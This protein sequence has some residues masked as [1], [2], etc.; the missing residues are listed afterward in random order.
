MPLT[1]PMTAGPALWTVYGRLV[2]KSTISESGAMSAPYSSGRRFTSYEMPS[3]WS[4]CR[5]ALTCQVDM[6]RTEPSRRCALRNGAVRSIAWGRDPGANLACQ[7]VW[8]HE[9]K[10][11][12]VASQTPASATAGGRRLGVRGAGRLALTRAAYTRYPRLVHRGVLALSA[13]LLVGALASA[14][15]QGRGRQTLPTL[16]WADVRELAGE[17]R[18]PTTREEPVSPE[19]ITRTGRVL[20][21]PLRTPEGAPAS[22]PSLATGLSTWA[23][24][25]A[26]SSAAP[27]A[28][29]CATPD[30]FC[31]TF[32]DAVELFGASALAELVYGSRPDAARERARRERAVDVVLIGTVTTDPA[33]LGI[34]AVVL[35]AASGADVWRGHVAGASWD[36]V[37]RSLGRRFVG[38]TRVVRGP[39]RV[40]PIFAM[41]RGVVGVRR[42]RLSLTSEGPHFAMSF[43]TGVRVLPWMAST[44]L[45]LMLGAAWRSGPRRE[46]M[47]MLGGGV[48]ALGGCG[49]DD[50]AAGLRLAYVT[51]W[52]IGESGFAGLELA[53]GGFSLDHVK[54]DA[55]ATRDAAIDYVSVAGALGFRLAPS[56]ALE[57]VTRFTFGE[58]VET[59]RGSILPPDHSLG[60]WLTPTVR[61]SRAF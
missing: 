3:P 18:V 58:S 43:E 45:T 53:I 34:D 21:M 20:V 36:E 51:R 29:G 5:C 4:S 61:I 33:G 2:S 7:R 30:G 57:V 44:E 8:A 52:A 31:L 42:V 40:E 26:A 25:D 54:C 22:V 11:S 50:A 41:R 27:G 10:S 19:I 47:L 1:T 56:T 48:A 59:L 49:A 38:A 55:S 46:H 14:G 12:A 60:A 39:D 32:V 37:A 13:A 35:D 15:C 24:R 28:P 16:V 17:N 6:T 23:A 9:A